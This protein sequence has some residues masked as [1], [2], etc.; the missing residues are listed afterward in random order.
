MDVRLREDGGTDV[1]WE[2][3]EAWRERAQ[4]SEGCYMLR[5]NM[6]DWDGEQLWQACFQFTEAEAA[7][8]I[9]KGDLGMRPIWHQKTERVQA[10]ILVY[11]L[12]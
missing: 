1:V 9:Q 2:K 6:A 12:A 11:F 7:F 10:H 4:L 8:Q 3:L 5:T